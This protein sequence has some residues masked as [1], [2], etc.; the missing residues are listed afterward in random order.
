MY[1]EEAKGHADLSL[2]VHL[3]EHKIHCAD[4]S[5]G[6]GDEMVSHHEVCTS[7]VS[8]TR[9]TNATPVRAI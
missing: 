5:N 8:E 3:A 1:G 9:R 7:K 6:I 2:P 4:D